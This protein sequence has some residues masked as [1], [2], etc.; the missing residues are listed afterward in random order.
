MMAVFTVSFISLG[1]YVKV[2]G[3]HQSSR[4]RIDED[5]LVRPVWCIRLV[6]RGG[7]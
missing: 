1:R 7:L 6:I 2:G 4:C 5:T 3:W